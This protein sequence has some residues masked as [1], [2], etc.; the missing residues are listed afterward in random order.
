MESQNDSFRSGYRCRTIL[1][2]E[3][4]IHKAVAWAISHN[5]TFTLS[6]DNVSLGWAIDFAVRYDE[7]LDMFEEIFNGTQAK[8]EI[9]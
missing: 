4:S 1:K 9:K 2:S 7:T 6:S 8:T 3:E 5:R